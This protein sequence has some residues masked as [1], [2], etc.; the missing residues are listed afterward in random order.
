MNQGPV[1]KWYPGIGDPRFAGWLTVLLYAAAAWFTWRLLS[2]WQELL[3]GT[4][5]Y[6]HRFWKVLLI[7]LVLLGINKQLD[8]QTALIE[9]GRS[10]AH[11]QGWHPERHKFQIAFI[12]GI[13]IVGLALLATA[14]SAMRG[15]PSAT[16][17]A[18]LGGTGLVL[19]VSI[20]ANS[21]HHVDA[22]LGLTISG[23]RINWLLETGG[24][25]AII[26]CAWLRR[27]HH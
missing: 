23:L 20:R 4:V 11:K 15:A 7:G 18:L 13:V 22:V 1:S 12:A 3:T 8:L 21:F 19:F 6:E 25:M 17:W 16:L 26:G 10:M 24:L 2:D 9:I 14:L 27:E 5:R